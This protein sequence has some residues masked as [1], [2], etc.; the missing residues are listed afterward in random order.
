MI[1]N[2]TGWVN[3]SVI[4]GYAEDSSTLKVKDLVKVKK[5]APDYQGNLLA[6]FVYDTVYEVMEIKGDRVV[7]GKN[8]QV[9]AAV[10]AKNL[11][12]V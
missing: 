12:K 3:N 5:N 10:A 7:I 2:G 8:N 6:P 4:D 11:I 9:T 1:N